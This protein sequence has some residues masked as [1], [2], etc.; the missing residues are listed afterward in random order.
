MANC[1]KC[2]AYTKF[3]GGLCLKCYDE[4]KEQ[5]LPPQTHRSL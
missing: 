5:K 4:N 3:D 1:T 2:G